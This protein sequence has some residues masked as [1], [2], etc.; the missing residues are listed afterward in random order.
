MRARAHPKKLPYNNQKNWEEAD[1]RENLVRTVIE[2][3]LFNAA[4]ATK[5]TRDLLKEMNLPMPATWEETLERSAERRLGGAIAPFMLEFEDGT[6]EDIEINISPAS[7]VNS[8][9]ADRVGLI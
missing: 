9:W 8:G 3:E 6:T 1:T 4:M 2:R 5:M 7:I